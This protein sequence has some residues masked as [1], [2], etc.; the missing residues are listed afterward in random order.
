MSPHCHP[1]NPTF[2]MF[3]NQSKGVLWDNERQEKFLI[4]L[5]LRTMGY[6]WNRPT[7]LRREE[8]QTLNLAD[9]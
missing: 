4:G 3:S 8:E 6:D 7:Y 2:R 9:L 5:E 1:L